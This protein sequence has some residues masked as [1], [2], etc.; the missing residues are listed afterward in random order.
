MS[1]SPILRLNCELTIP[2]PLFSFLRAG[3]GFE[4]GDQLLVQLR[5]RKH[6]LHPRMAFPASN[7]R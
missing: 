6:I 1:F 7:E 2:F 4:Q 5:M 3:V